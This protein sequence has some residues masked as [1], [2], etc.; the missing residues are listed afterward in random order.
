MSSIIALKINL[1]KIDK[2]KI[3]EGEKGNYLNLTVAI[4]DDVNDYGQNVSSWIEQTQ[5]ERESKKDR[6]YVGNGKVIFTDGNIATAPKEEK[7]A[8]KKKAV[9][10]K[11][12][13]PF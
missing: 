2:S 7:T 13:L 3:V 1:S 9:K 12:D 8:P 6:V 11:N 5:E 4:N 10:S